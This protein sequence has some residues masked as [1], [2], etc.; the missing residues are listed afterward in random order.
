MNEAL[1]K[2]NDLVAFLS[3]RVAHYEKLIN[4]ESAR[5][6]ALAQAIV[7]QKTDM[8]KREAKL[9]PFENALALMDQAKAAMREAEILRDTVNKAKDAF[10][11]SVEEK[12]A[13]ISKI[14]NQVNIDRKKADSAMAMVT[15]EWSALKKE[16]D[17]WKAKFYE[18]LKLKVK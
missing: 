1:I 15:K 5:Q 4:V 7:E 17:T 14:S 18:E 9:A 6:N 10:N 13:E 12:L 3:Q 16:Q 8:I 11:K 2:I